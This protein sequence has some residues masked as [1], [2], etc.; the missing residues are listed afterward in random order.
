MNQQQPMPKQQMMPQTQMAQ[1]QSQ[2]MMQ[3]MPNQQ[4]N[5]MQV[6]NQFMVPNQ[7]MVQPQMMP[8]QMMGQP[9][10]MPSQAMGQPQMPVVN[11]QPQQPPAPA[12]PAQKTDRKKLKNA[13]LAKPGTIKKD[14]EEDKN[15]EDRPETDGATTSIPMILRDPKEVVQGK[16]ASAS[17]SQS[18]VN[19]KPVNGILDRQKM[20]L[21]WRA[22]K[23]LRHETS[24]TLSVGA[25]LDKSTPQLGKRSPQTR[26]R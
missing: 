7:M 14:G 11:Q 26:T 12:A 5:M 3:Q 17:S 22:C 21:I 19:V 13:V 9:Q 25:R 8:N 15:G 20:L 2:P 1:M 23:A 18:K 10:M 16:S 4:M 24:K 6:P